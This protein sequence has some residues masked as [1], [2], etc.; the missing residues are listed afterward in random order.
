MKF[1]CN[2]A[3]MGVFQPCKMEPVSP[4]RLIA[5]D[6]D[7]TLLDSSFRIP[8]ANLTVLR[9]AHAA[10]IEVVLVTGR[11]HAF[12]L[13]IADLL[14]FDLALISSNGAMTRSSS[15]ELFH[16]DVLPRD[17]ARELLTEM[18]DFRGNTVLTFDRDGKG[19]LVLEHMNELS[20]S[21][22]RWLEKNEEFIERIAPIEQA[23]SED[24]IQAMF[25]GQL[26]R[27]KQ[28]QD[29]LAAS[30]V[31]AKITA[32][33][34]E[35][36]QRDLCIVDVLNRDCSKGHAL[37]RWAE[38]RG[39]APAEVV[40]IGDNYNDVEMLEFAGVPVI[41]G[42]AAEELKQNGWHVTASND[43]AGVA[44]AIERFAQL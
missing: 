16:R 3:E 36:P 26:G 24:P 9:R 10:G 30:S 13:P 11:R 28:A 5:I 34:T 33:K 21:I 19:A 38:E 35:Y 15:G 12:A 4:I 37:R 8:E 23:L 31:F 42:N 1:D 2:R 39:F 44:S 43:E 14:G 41:M 17:T 25:C 27:M 40:A 6:I 7:G 32:L 20:G 18:A 22:A 29:K